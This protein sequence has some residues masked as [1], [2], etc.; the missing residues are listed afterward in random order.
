MILAFMDVV[1]VCLQ[2][3]PNNGMTPTDTDK[4]PH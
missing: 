3:P 1:N 4:V 2:M